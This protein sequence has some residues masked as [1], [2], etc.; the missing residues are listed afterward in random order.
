MILNHKPIGDYIRLVDERNI[1][2][3]TNNLLGLTIAKTFISSVANIIGTDMENYKIIRR[4][5]FACSTMQVRRDGKMPIALLADVNEAIISQAYPVF[6][7]ID[8]KQL[9]PEYLMMWFSRKE[10]DREACFYAIGGVRGSLEWNDFCGM[11]LPVPSIEKQRE[12]VAEYNV[13]QN[14][15]ALNNKLIENLEAVAQAIY[16][17]WFVD[18]EF[19]NCEGKPYRSN[20]GEMEESEIGELPKGWQVTNIKDFCIDMKSGGTPSRYDM[21]HW[22]KKDIPWLKTGEIHNN[23]VHKAEEYISENGF[24]SSSA[25]M[26]PKDT[27]LMAMYGATAGQ[28][29]ILKFEA[30]TNQACCGMICKNPKQAAYLYYNLLYNQ[31][32]IKSQAIGGAQENLSKNFIEKLTILKPADEILNS[33]IFYCITNYKENLTLEIDKLERISELLLAKMAKKG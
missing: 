12:I 30:C 24:K 2:L 21:D 33:N 15:I 22:I 5:Q 28:L 18:F 17:Q 4:N 8:E 10:F 11:R 19:P 26:L 32:Y 29:G 31:E 13:I 9:L 7:V 16:K 23:I 27:I 14:R 6:E 3:K 1:G 25:K 20:G